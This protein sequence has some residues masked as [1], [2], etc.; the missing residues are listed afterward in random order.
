MI[1]ERPDIFLLL[2]WLEPLVDWK[3]FGLGLPGITHSDILKIEAEN[4]KIDEQKSALYSKWLKM[5]PTATWADVINALSNNKE[6]TLVQDIRRNL[7]KIAPRSAR[8][9]CDITTRRSSQ[10]EVM[11]KTAEDEK[12]ILDTLFALNKEFSLLMMHAR[13]GLGKKTEKDPKILHKLTIWLETYMHWN[14]FEKLANIS[15]DEAFKII[16]PFY[17]FIDC[18]LIVEMSEIFLQDLKFG[19]DELSIVS[20]LKKHKEKADKLRFSANEQVDL[21]V[22]RNSGGNAFKPFMSACQNGHIQIVK[23]LL[24]ERVDL[25]VQNRKGHTALMVASSKGHYEV[26]K[27]LLEWEADPTINSNEGH[28]AISLSKDSEISKLIYNYMYK[29]G[30]VKL[31]EDAASVTE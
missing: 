12:E 14:E 3:P 30:N 24:K 5:A 10:A 27:L 22:Q 8:S 13:L 28:T 1:D 4:K 6:N 20:E 31:E 21:N 7:Q 16:H 2:Q 23:L 26:V 18:S 25:N 17:D 29:K 11:F 15:S 9:H 19:D